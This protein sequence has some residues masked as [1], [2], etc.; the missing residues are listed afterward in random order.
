MMNNF[1]VKSN[2]IHHF[3]DLPI[4]RPLPSQIPHV[5][6][7]YPIHTFFTFLPLFCFSRIN[8]KDIF[9]K[10]F[11]KLPV[12]DFLYIFKKKN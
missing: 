6:V 10:K 3:L 1:Q 2:T 4:G 8:L 11:I 7:V 12:R 5:V 9:L